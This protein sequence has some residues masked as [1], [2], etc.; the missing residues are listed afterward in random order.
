M[1]AYELM[2]MTDPSLDDEARE[3]V[4]SRAS[5]VIKEAEGTVDEVDDWGKRRLAYE[6]DDLSDAHYTVV[7]FHASPDSVAELDRVLRITDPVIR[8]MIV[9]REDL[10]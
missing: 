9:R 6:I 2:L 8:H 4:V 1:K 10:P 5:D 7:Q 3:A